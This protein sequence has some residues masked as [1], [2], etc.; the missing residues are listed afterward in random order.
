MVCYK[1]GS[2]ITCIIAHSMIDALSLFGADNKIVDWIYV[3]TSII[4]A[5]VYSIYLG[6][7][8][9]PEADKKC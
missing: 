8:K 5:I 3:G 1:S 2:I 4:V 9:T 7:L 6:R